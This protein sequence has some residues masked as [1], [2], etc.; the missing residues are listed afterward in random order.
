[1]TED[2]NKTN[3]G[4]TKGTEDPKALAPDGEPLSDYDKAL[5]LVERREKATEEERKVLEEKK[6]LAANDMIGGTAG[7]H[8]ETKPEK[9]ETPKEYNDRIDKEISDGKHNE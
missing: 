9:E 1:M 5:A 2:D 7:G 8:V 4:D 3:E 6:K